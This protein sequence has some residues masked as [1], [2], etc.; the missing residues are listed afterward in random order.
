MRNQEKPVMSLEEKLEKVNT[1]RTL[2]LNGAKMMNLLASDYFLEENSQIDIPDIP[3]A[4]KEE[5]IGVIMEQMIEFDEKMWK[6]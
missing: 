4:T 5:D 1:L 3:V 6:C 2:C